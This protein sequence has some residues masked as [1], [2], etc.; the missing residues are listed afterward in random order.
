[1]RSDPACREYVTLED[2]EHFFEPTRQGRMEAARAFALFDW[3]KSGKVDRD[4]VRA[5]ETPPSGQLR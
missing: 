1:M 2:F 4:E 5:R 3:D